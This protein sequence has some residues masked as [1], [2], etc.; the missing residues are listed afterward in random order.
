MLSVEK[1]KQRAVREREESEANSREEVDSLRA[2]EVAIKDNNQ[3]IMRWGDIAFC[4]YTHRH[5][6]NG[7]IIIYKHWLCH[8]FHYTFVVSF[9]VHFYGE[10]YIQK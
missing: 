7:I 2:K 1:E 8:R 9:T 10:L 6:L 4:S 3:A 5:A